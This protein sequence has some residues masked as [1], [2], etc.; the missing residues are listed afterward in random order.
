MSIEPYDGHYPE[1]HESVY[2]HPSAVIIGRVKIGALSSIW[3]GV[4]IRGDVNAIE[5]GERTNVQDGSILHVSRPSE[6]QPEG[7]P[8][9]IG[10]DITIAHKVLLHGCTLE[11]HVMIGMGTI[12]MDDVKVKKEAMIAAASL[13]P[14]RKIIP[15]GE[16]WMGSPAKYLRNLTSEAL[17]QNQATTKHYLKVA[18]K[19]RQQETS[20]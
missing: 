3:P 18:D 14:P 8:L 12:I 5:I 16:L 9:I 13:V 19:Y 10:D 15:P 11:N 6:K 7:S 4:V 17:Q 1:I 20:S 2:I